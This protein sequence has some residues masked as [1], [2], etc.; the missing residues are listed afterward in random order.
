[1]IRLVVSNQR[2]GVA[3][4]TTAVILARSFAAH[5]LKVLLIDTDSQGSIRTILGLKP[6]FHLADFLVRN[7]AFRE[8]VVEACKNVHVMC[9]NRDTTEAEVTLSNSPFRELTFERLFS[10]HEAAYDV[11][12]MDVAPSIT[13]SQQCAMVY[14]QQVLVPVGMETLSLQGAVA[15]VNA[16]AALNRF[17]KKGLNIRT[18][19]LLPV[20]VDRRL[21]LTGMVLD[22]LKQLS[23][24]TGVPVLPVI[25]TDSAVPKAARARQFLADF[26]PNSKALAD[27]NEVA[28]LLLKS[29]DSK[30]ARSEAGEPQAKSA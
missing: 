25:R 20:M 5:G 17:F 9:S 1:M 15:A 24:D 13:L 12:L 2:G 16:A 26:D 19:G 23:A 7:R 18:I 21:A 4:T 22:S 29:L 30:N 11:V 6:E 14:A 3:K 10:D 28:S 8:C 27:Y